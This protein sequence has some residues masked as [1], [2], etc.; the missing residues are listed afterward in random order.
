MAMLSLVR[1]THTRSAQWTE[2]GLPEQLSG[3][4][5]PLIDS[6]GHIKIGKANVTRIVRSGPGIQTGFTTNEGNCHVCI[7]SRAGDN[8]GV[9]LQAG[10]QID[11]QHRQRRLVH[12][13]DGKL[14]VTGQWPIHTSTQHGIDQHV[15][16]Q[17]G[18]GRKGRDLTA[19]RHKIAMCCERITLQ[20][21]GLPQQQH[22][23]AP[24]RRQRQTRNNKTVTT[25]IAGATQNQQRACRRPA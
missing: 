7:D 5:H 4:W 2:Q 13:F 16:L 21:F 8:T 9:C 25:I 19:H 17:T 24:V 1:S 18:R 23:H 15:R 11:R 14:P 20:P 6:L 12:A 3:G 10:G 22:L